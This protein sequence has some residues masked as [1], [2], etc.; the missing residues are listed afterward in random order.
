MKAPPHGSYIAVALAYNAADTIARA[1]DSL[2]CQTHTDLAHAESGLRFGVS[3]ADVH[4][5]DHGP[6]RG[7]AG[8][9]SAL[10]EDMVSPRASPRCLRSFRV[11]GYGRTRPGP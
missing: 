5:H 6:P 10:A 8:P 2:L 7:V 3:G 1:I 9:L 4:S 11:S